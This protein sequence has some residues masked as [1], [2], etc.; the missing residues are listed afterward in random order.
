MVQ[1]LL[2]SLLQALMPKRKPLNRV[3]IPLN[4]KRLNRYDQSSP[5]CNLLLFYFCGLYYIHLR[6]NIFLLW[7]GEANTFCVDI[8]DQCL[9]LD[10]YIIWFS[11][12]IVLKI[13]LLLFEI[14]D[15]LCF[16][17]KEILT[18]QTNFHFNDFCHLLCWKWLITYKFKFNIDDFYSSINRENMNILL[19]WTK[20]SYIYNKWT[21]CIS[22]W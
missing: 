15:P 5:L 1:L 11:V 22:L 18:L 8:C 4:I 21:F 20:W 13:A 16:L 10:A 14:M 19:Q 6:K 9:C 17:L 3:L 2:L 12:L 7:W